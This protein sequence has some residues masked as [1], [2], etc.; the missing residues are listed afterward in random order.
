MLG[1]SNMSKDYKCPACQNSVDRS[2]TVC[3]N[4]V[5]RAD[6]AFCSHCFDITTYT[7]AEKGEGRFS[8]DKFKCARCERIGVKCLNWLAG[9]YCN[10]LARAS[11]GR[12][13]QAAVRQLQQSRRRSRAHRHRLVARR[14]LRRPAQAAQVMALRTALD[15]VAARALCAA[16]GLSLE[17]LEPLPALGTVNSNFRVHASR[18]VWFLR[19]NEGKTEADVAAEVALVDRLRA[20]GLPTPAIVRACDGRAIVSA[21]GRPATLFPWLD[22]KEAQ[23]NAKEPSTVALAGSA[24]AQ[25]HRAGSGMSAAELP[26]NHYSLDALEKRLESFA[27]DLR[28]AD[29]VPA[30]RYELDRARRRRPSVSGLIHQD[31]FPD[32]VLVDGAGA[33]V[34]LLDFEQATHGLLLYDVAVALNAWCWTGSRIHQ[35]AVD[36]LL[37][38]Y[39]AVRPL[40]P[41]ERTRLV[42]EARLA[43]ARFAIT[44]ITDVFLPE[45]VDPELRK[46]KDFR[47]YVRR[48]EWWINRSG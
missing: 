4:P 6:L 2:A 43:A 27:D 35:P 22:G 9:G 18:R 44:R 26:R 42:D 38:A 7:L 36:A 21:A 11:D 32:N 19:L 16:Y 48:L 40:E 23:P 31:L 13:R 25:L 30:L 1:F 41:A 8:R 17:S 28:V 24:L 15:E 5:C 14:R 10:G 34:A 47:E 12:A 46:R 3:S 45:G 33:L 39:E 20:R 37:R 29:I